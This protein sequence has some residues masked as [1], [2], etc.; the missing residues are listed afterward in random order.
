MLEQAPEL[1][2]P[3]APERAARGAAARERAPPQ[4]GRR[5][6]ALVSERLDPE[7]LHELLDRCAE[8][9]EQH[10]GTVESVSGESVVGVFG[11]ERLHEDD[12]L[13][14]ARA[15]AAL[16]DAGERVR[17]GIEAGEVFV[18][19]GA[20]RDTFA[21][22]G[23]IGVAAAL[24]AHAAPGEVLIGAGAHGLMG[25]RVLAEP[26]ETRRGGS[27]AS[28][29][30]RRLKRGRRPPR[31][32]AAAGSSTRSARRSPSPGA[33]RRRAGSRWSGRR[34]SASPGSR[35]RPSRGWAPARPS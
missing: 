21:T 3:A 29:R 6:V 33:S 9:I 1:D 12:A 11:L 4:A 19:A 20:R 32:S 24:A 8:V 23:A 30:R 17:L 15:A 35:T 25:T 34:A 14:A 10:G 16:R 7:A 28:R 31:S 18:A 2:A 26:L 27:T 5:P 22:G 13:R